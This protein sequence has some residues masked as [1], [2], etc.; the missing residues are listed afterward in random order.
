MLSNIVSYPI[1]YGGDRSISHT[2]F[3]DFQDTIIVTCLDSSKC[4]RIC[5]Q[6]SKLKPQV[7]QALLR[8]R[9]LNG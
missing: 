1:K 9:G 5:R 7:F 4:H 8:M 3:M 6:S 2:R